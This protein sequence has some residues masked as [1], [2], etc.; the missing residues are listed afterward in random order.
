VYHCFPC[1]VT[2]CLLLAGALMWPALPSCST[3]LPVDMPCSPQLITVINSC[4][5]VSTT[6]LGYCWCGLDT[7]TLPCPLA[8]SQVWLLW[9]SKNSHCCSAACNFR[10]NGAG[11]QPDMHDCA[12]VCVCVCALCCS[13]V[14]VCCPRCM[15]PLTGVRVCMGRGSSTQL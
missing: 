14:G 1:F 12:S 10:P 15:G 5:I 13:P 6:P 7:H 11:W 9:C 8:P 3:L 2:G 4:N